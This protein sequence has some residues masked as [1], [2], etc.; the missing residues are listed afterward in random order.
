[1]RLRLDLAYDGGDFHGWAA[2]PGLR[3]VQGEL[4]QALAM[5]LRLERVPVTCAGRTDTGVHARGQVVH[6]DVE[7]PVLLSAA[8]RSTQPPVEALAR[9]LN[10]V[11]APDVRVRGARPAPGAFDARFGA[12]W[13]RS[14][15]RLADQPAAIDPLARGHVVAWGRPLDAG[16]MDAASQRLLGEH[17][18]AAYCRQRE[19]ATTVRRLLELRWERTGAGVLEGTVRADAFCHS[20]VRSLVGAL[21]A[22]GEGRRGVEWP[23][24]VLARA[25]RDPRVLVMPPHGLTLEEVAYPEDADLAARAEVTRAVRSGG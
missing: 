5:I 22:V 6:L 12:L 13:R 14:V 17:D 7:E 11:L 9:R 1:M 4:E 20:M 18:F 24:E 23:G 25:V 21:V 16:P 8:G 19:G 2:Q 3:T 10:G 15:Y